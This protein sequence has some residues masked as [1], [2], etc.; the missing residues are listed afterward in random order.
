MAWETQNKDSIP[1]RSA[2]GDRAGVDGENVILTEKQYFCNTFSTGS[3]LLLLPVISSSFHL[4]LYGVMSLGPSG[5]FI[6][7]L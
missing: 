1:V 4:T 6:G 2:T 3:F 7:W 5:I